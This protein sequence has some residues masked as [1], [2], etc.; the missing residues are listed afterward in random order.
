MPLPFNHSD[1]FSDSQRSDA[2]RL[3][4][5]CY[6]GWTTKPGAIRTCKP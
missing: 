2:E 1:A 6:A 5:I 3:F 4:D